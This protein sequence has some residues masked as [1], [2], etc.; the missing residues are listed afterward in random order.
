MMR[1]LVSIILLS[2]SIGAWYFY[3]LPKEV[4]PNLGAPGVT[5]EEFTAD[6]TVEQQ[7]FL[8]QYADYIQVTADGRLLWN[9]QEINNNRFKN[10]IPANTEIHVYD[11]PGGKGFQILQADAGVFRSFAIGP[12]AAER[13][14]TISPYPDPEL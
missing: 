2:A 7:D 9:G 11:S 5:W 1:Y 8:L 12:E 14:Y 4:E 6:I 3:T 10:K 13:T